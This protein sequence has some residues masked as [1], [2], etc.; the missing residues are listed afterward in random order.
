MKL[1][2]QYRRAWQSIPK[3]TVE[4]NGIAVLMCGSVVLHNWQESE[5][6]TRSNVWNRARRC[7]SK[8]TLKREQILRSAVPYWPNWRSREKLVLLWDLFQPG[9]CT[10][11][12]LCLRYAVRFDTGY[13]S[14]YKTQITMIEGINRIYQS[15]KALK[16]VYRQ[17]NRYIGGTQ[18]IR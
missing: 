2:Q 4:G 9:R 13:R 15:L 8:Q 10:S 7:K 12:K 3:P 1:L 16:D 18:S 5:G 11:W 17:E 6:P 14:R